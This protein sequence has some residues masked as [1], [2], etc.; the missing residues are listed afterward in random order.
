[1]FVKLKYCIFAWLFS[2]GVSLNNFILPLKLHIEDQVLKAIALWTSN[3]AQPHVCFLQCNSRGAVWH[4]SFLSLKINA[5]L[6]ISL[7]YNFH[8][9][10]GLLL[11][12]INSFSHLNAVNMGFIF[13]MYKR[14]TPRAI[15][16]LRL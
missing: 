9:A 13:C 7:Q 2:S 4:W 8:V 6:N 5:G 14:L 10:Q 15:P 12:K 1:M 3:E 16:L 11:C